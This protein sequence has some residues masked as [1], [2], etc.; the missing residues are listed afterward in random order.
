MIGDEDVLDGTDEPVERWERTKFHRKRDVLVAAVIAVAALV[1]G[2][3]LWQSSDIEATTSQ[4]YGGTATTPPRPTV[5]PPSLGEV[6]R[7]T[8]PATPEPVA[9]GPVVVTGN[10]GEVAGRDPLSGKVRWRYTRD[11]PLCT[12]AGAWQM[13]VAVYAKKDNLLR[14]DDPRKAGGCSEVTALWPDTGRRGRPPAD[15]E[16]QDKPD[17]GQRDSD[18]E[19]GTRLLFDGSYLTTTG[20]RLLTT[21]RSDLVQTMEYGKIPAIVNPDKQ[22]RTGCT[23]GTISVVTGKIAVIEHCPLDSGDRLTVYK[24]TGEDNDAE[25]PVV[26]ASVAVSKGAQVVAMSEQCR[27]D[28]EKPDDV[29]QCTAIALPDPNRLV[30]MDEKGKLVKTYPLSIG[31]GD[32]RT[33]PADH[34]VAVSRVTGAVYWFTG[35][36]TIALSLEDMRP[37]W[38][39]DRALGPGTAFAGKILVPVTGAIAVLDPAT[40]EQVAS[41]PVDR[42]GYRGLVT[43]SKLGPVVLEQRGNTLVAL[44]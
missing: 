17:Q 29:Q 38:T 6:W 26:V 20:T 2:L 32:L 33:E 21:W 30:V 23:Y 5:F 11:L 37:L 7:A 13:A 31:A 27:L 35:S 39:V 42:D 24:A 43:M 10:G 9:A 4:T 36:K 41:T 19:L 8:S 34:T 16:E 22:P 18:A 1:G 14:P 28:P 40:G 15:G 3:L 25:E 12:V 44:R